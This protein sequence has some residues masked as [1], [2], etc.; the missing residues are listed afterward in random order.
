MA[1]NSWWD[2]KQAIELCPTER[3]RV[4][5]L[6]GDDAVFLTRPGTPPLFFGKIPI[7]GKDSTTFRVT[8]DT[9]RRIRDQ[10]PELMEQLEKCDLSTINPFADPK[11]SL[12]R[13][14]RKVGE[15]LDE[16]FAIAITVLA[17]LTIIAVAN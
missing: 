9:W 14:G 16:P 12:R 7:G 2:F 13:T 6:P 17:L 3:G 5:T 1:I 11:L 8:E 4:S 10:E 15:A